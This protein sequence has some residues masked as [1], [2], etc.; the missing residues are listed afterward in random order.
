MKR[1]TTVSMLHI[2][3]GVLTVSATLLV[4]LPVSSDVPPASP[5]IPAPVATGGTSDVPSSS[6][7]D[8]AGQIVNSNLFSATR[9]APRVAFVAPGLYDPS[10]AAT[11]DRAVS[12]VASDA[13]VSPSDVLL[14]GIVI[15][16]GEPR[17]LLRVPHG[18]HDATTVPRLVAPGDRIGAY[19]VRSIGRDHVV[20]ASAGGV[21]TLRLQRQLPSDSSARRP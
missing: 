21:R 15:R 9:R 16:D 18:E 14:E 10:V 7:R 17:A 6:G 2:L 12:D 1:P 3:A 19:R 5:R 11:D 13:A 4:V 20:L 8:L